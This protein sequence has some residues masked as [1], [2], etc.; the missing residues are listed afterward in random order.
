MPFSPLVTRFQLTT[1]GST[2]LKSSRKNNPF[3]KLLSCEQHNAQL[4]PK[5][6]RNSDM[7]WGEKERMPLTLK[8]SMRDLLPEFFTLLFAQYRMSASVISFPWE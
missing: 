2:A 1:L 4:R 7:R 3:D 6:L 8:L 5:L